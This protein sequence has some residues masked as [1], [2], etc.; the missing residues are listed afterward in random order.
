MTSEEQDS[1]A[2]GIPENSL[3]PKAPH[4]SGY[5]QQRR[6]RKPTAAELAARAADARTTDPPPATPAT[7]V[8]GEAVTGL[9][10]APPTNPQEVIR[11]A[12]VRGPEAEL[13]LAQQ[14]GVS[15]LAH[16]QYYVGL[17]R[18]QRKFLLN[19]ALVESDKEA[20]N[21][22]GV[23]IGTVGQWKRKNPTFMRAYA[24]LWVDPVSVGRTMLANLVPASVAKLEEY[25]T[26]PGTQA[27]DVLTAIRLVMESQQL[28]DPPTI[29]PGSANSYEQALAA[30]MASRGMAIPPALQQATQIVVQDGGRVEIHNDGG[31]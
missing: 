22:A 10:N 3:T 7:L 31:E 24:S 1:G 13:A 14:L 21:F 27:K 11:D 29:Q 8:E 6:A 19:R 9:H 20:A 25:I 30:R 23:S 12:M 26:M 15:K 16:D 5:H 18:V 4:L 2:A 28:L 17:S